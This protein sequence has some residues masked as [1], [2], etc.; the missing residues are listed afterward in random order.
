MKIELTLALIVLFFG[1]ITLF[2]VNTRESQI[3]NLERRINDLK[4]TTDS[5]YI[6]AGL[7]VMLIS[8]WM[9]YVSLSYIYSLV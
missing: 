7:V 1:V 2:K 9:I 3:K 6:F 8:G 5:T 4:Y